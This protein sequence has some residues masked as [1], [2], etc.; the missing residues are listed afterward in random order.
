MI[1]S[2]FVSLPLYCIPLSTQIRTPNFPPFSVV[3]ACS[4]ATIILPTI[5]ITHGKS[6][7]P[8]A[9]PNPLFSF[10]SS[11]KRHRSSDTKMYQE[12]VSSS[13]NADSP[14]QKNINRIPVPIH[15]FSSTKCMQMCEM[16]YVDVQKSNVISFHGNIHGAEYLSY[17]CYLPQHFA[18]GTSAGICWTSCDANYLKL[19]EMMGF[20]ID[21]QPW[22][23]TFLTYP[24]HLSAARLLRRS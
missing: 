5:T 16:N 7:S 18:S 22:P 21:C 19:V 10:L 24:H 12:I 4:K 1:A 23:F 2:T 15:R 14:I 6:H 20:I 3:S 11:F 8:H 9:L 13:F 17:E